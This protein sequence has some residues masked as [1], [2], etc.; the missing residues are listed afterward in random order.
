MAEVSLQKPWEFI[1]DDPLPGRNEKPR[2]SGWTMLIDTGLG[3]RQ[4]M[5]LAEIASGYIDFLKIGFGTSQLYGKSLL[6]NK[7]NMLRDYQIHVYPG[8]TLL[9]SAVMQ[10]RWKEFMQEAKK[11]GFSAIEVSDGTLSISKG[12]RKQLIEEARDLGF[13]VLSEVGKKEEGTH[14]PIAEQLEIIEQDLEAGACKVIMEG[15]ESGKSVGIYEANGNIRENDMDF[16]LNKISSPDLIIWEAPL[17]SQQQEL[18]A[19]LGGNVNLG[20]IAP[21]DILSVEALRRGLRSDTLRH[22]VQNQRE[23]EMYVANP[24]RFMTSIYV[25]GQ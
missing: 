17:K 3:I 19:R 4:T 11:I 13:L 5:D 14:L 15:R 18:I 8:G 9:E 22:A 20:N 12:L 10:N 23:S 7:I 2:I 21:H 16:L 25:E 24:S 1:L 6:L